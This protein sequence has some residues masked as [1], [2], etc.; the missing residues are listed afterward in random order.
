MAIERPRRLLHASVILILFGSR[1][2]LRC[3]EAYS[4]KRYHSE[5]GYLMHFAII[6][7]GNMGCLYGSNLARIG[8]TVTMIDVWPEHVDAMSRDGL[9]MTGLHGD[10][11]APVAATTDPNAVD[12]ADVAIILTSTNE[13]ASA[14]GIAATVLKDDGYALTLQNG[15]GNVE[16][17]DPILGENRTMAGL[18]FHSADLTAPG[19]VTHSNHGPTYI[20]ERDRSKS[21]RHETLRSLLAEAGMDPVVEDDIMSTIWGK[22]VHNCGINAICAI[23]DLRPG[24]IGQ[25]TELDAFQTE[26]IRETMALVEARGITIPDSEPMTTVKDYCAKKFHRVSMLQHLARQRPT[27][28]DALN[29]YVVSESEKLGLMA[30][31]NDA[32]TKLMKGRHYFPEIDEDASPIDWSKK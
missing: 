21:E 11:V 2:V 24:H 31:Y 19:H 18:S 16:Q 27:E 6:G 15:L 7:A 8:Q 32:L 26:I 9:T 1:Y 25:I 29:G 13:T 10:F 23:T 30:P 5:S 28:I 20:G 22:F 17:I 3:A 14:A 12:P 4:N